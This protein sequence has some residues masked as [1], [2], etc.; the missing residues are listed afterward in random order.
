MVTLD[1]QW[2]KL[3]QGVNERR[4][5]ALVEMCW[6]PTVAL[7]QRFTHTLTE[8]GQFPQGKACGL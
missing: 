7:H 6:F 4:R 3:E 5:A 1:E 2:L 8:R